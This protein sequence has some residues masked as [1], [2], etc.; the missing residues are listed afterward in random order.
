MPLAK[1]ASVTPATRL[2]RADESQSV[3][4]RVRFALR[5]DDET[6]S[7]RVSSPPDARG[8]GT[9]RSRSKKRRLFDT[10]PNMVF[11]KYAGDRGIS[12]L[13][14]LRLKVSPPNV[15]ND[16]F[17]LTP[18][19]KFTITVDYMLNRVRNEPEWFREPYNDMVRNEGY[20]HSFDRFLADMPAVIPMKFK[21]YKK[22]YR[23]AQIRNDLGSMDEA[24]Q[25]MG[26]LCVSKPNDSIAMWSHY[27]N[28]HRGV[29]LGLELAHS[30]FTGLAGDFDAVRYRRNRCAVDALL[31]ICS[32]EW[33]NQ[34]KT[35]MFTKSTI[36]NYEQEHR[37]IYRL[38]DLLCPP[39]G[40]DGK[41][42]YFL[43]IDGDAIREIIFG[44]C[45][46]PDYEKQI[47]Q[48]LNR[49]PRTFGH[50]RLFRCER[51]RSRFQIQIV[52][53]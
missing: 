31:P 33:Y 28:H 36:W 50:V 45:I 2:L 37:R 11:Y 14:D 6:K 39:A 29:A 48:E 44:C 3:R 41:R 21:A 5:G 40:T 16:P 42:H 38:R 10:M 53:A 23:E 22:L 47:R 32:V 17:E 20:P 43:N 49:R 12:I 46:T 13:E 25:Y 7:V 24:S 30:C 35:V 1:P 27:A 8:L 9:D 51:H 26:I 34:L 19:S 15:F 4:A 52:P 18:R